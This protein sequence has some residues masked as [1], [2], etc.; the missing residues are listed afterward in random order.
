MVF[1]SQIL[2]NF[3]EGSSPI[4]VADDAI[5]ER[6]IQPA[7]LDLRLGNVAHCMKAVGIPK[8]G[9]KIK[10]L[11]ER[12]RAYSFNLN[13]RGILEKG[14]QY[15][16]ELKEGLRLPKDFFAVF[17]PKS[18]IGRVG[19]FVRVLM[20]DTQRYDRT[21]RGYQGN[22]YLEIIPLFF[23]IKVS[24]N[25]SLVQIRIKEKNSILTNAELQIVHSNH[26]IVYDKDEK[27]MR[28]D[29]EDDGLYLN[30]DLSSEII[31]FEAR[32]NSSE[33]IDL[34][35]ENHYI[36][37]DFW[38]P[39]KGP[40]EEC[41]LGRDHFYLLS[42]KERIKIPDDYSAEMVEYSLG[43][44][45]FRVHYAGFFDNGFGGERGTSGVL[46]V[47]VRD[48]PVRVF[49]N[50]RICKMVFEKTYETPQKL[51]GTK[52]GSHYVGSG[53]SLSKYFK[54]GQW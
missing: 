35:K 5:G 47:H 27:I 42:T 23:S 6:Q 21:K 18:S 37:E 4:I 22:L 33:I 31:G 15:I 30:I 12:C 8:P 9:E 40:R 43:I 54:K 10:D 29:T 45:E 48:V 49:D 1:P 14:C 17:S 41:I 7:S 50:Q 13:E 19:V 39:I 53:P 34:S 52:T 32:G 51:Y 24:E 38:N 44:G 36:A 3:I 28:A 11:I 16:I 20:D 46:E 25:L 26:G 2:M